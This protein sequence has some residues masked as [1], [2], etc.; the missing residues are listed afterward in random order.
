MGAFK[1]LGF[2]FKLCLVAWMWHACCI[3]FDTTHIYWMQ[4]ITIYQT[5]SQTQMVRIQSPWKC[6]YTNPCVLTVGLTYYKF[7][8]QIIRV[9][10]CLVTLVMVTSKSKSMYK[11]NNLFISLITQ[12]HIIERVV[13]ITVILNIFPSKSLKPSAE[14]MIIVMEMEIFIYEVRQPPWSYEA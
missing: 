10:S 1:E 6:L 5:I 4:N 8:L 13:K 9:L 7:Y 3:L 2:M 11:C 14:S 12:Q